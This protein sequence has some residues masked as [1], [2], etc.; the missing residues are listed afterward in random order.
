MSPDVERSPI[1]T[2]LVSDTEGVKRRLDAANVVLSL[3]R[4]RLR[5]SPALYN[6]ETDIDILINALHA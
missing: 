1:A 5:V 4:G 2:F 3:G 6:T